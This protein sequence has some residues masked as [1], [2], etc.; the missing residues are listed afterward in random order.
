MESGA[1][2]RIFEEHYDRVFRTAYRI[3]GNSSDAEDIAQTVF[4]R[5]ARRQQEA[6][7]VQHPTTYLHRAAVH[8]ALDLLR[9]KRVRS[10][11]SLDDETI[12]HDLSL[13]A[14]AGADEAVPIRL[15]LR[16]A[17][18]EL[19]PRQAEIF[20]LRYIEGYENHEIARMVGTSQIVIGVTLHRVRGLLKGQLETMQ[21]RAK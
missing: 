16:K 3:I 2:A 1:L 7:A 9:S 17:L 8:A 5:L 14:R 18:S 19:T 15:W 12:D 21:K 20:T 13:S 11:V 4:L 6:A 10:S